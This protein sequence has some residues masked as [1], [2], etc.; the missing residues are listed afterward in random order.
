MDLLWN[1]KTRLI[2]LILIS[3]LTNVIPTTTFAQLETRSPYHEG[4]DMQL[5]TGTQNATLPSGLCDNNGSLYT[6]NPM[7]AI[8]QNLPTITC[9]D[10]STIGP[11]NGT[12]VTHCSPTP[13]CPHGQSPMPDRTCLPPCGGSGN[14]TCMWK[15]TDGNYTQSNAAEQFMYKTKNYTDYT[16]N[17]G[18]PGQTICDQQGLECYAFGLAAGSAHSGTPCPTLYNN[19]TKQQQFCSGYKDGSTN[20]AK[21][22]SKGGIICDNENNTGCHRDITNATIGGYPCVHG[23]PYIPDR[24]GNCPPPTYMRSPASH[25]NVSCGQILC[26]DLGWNRGQDSGFQHCPTAVDALPVSVDNITIVNRGQVYAYCNGFSDGEQALAN[27][28]NIRSHVSTS[29]VLP[30]NATGF[31]DTIKIMPNGSAAEIGHS[32]IINQTHTSPRLN[33]A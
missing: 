28:P 16:F 14:M 3:F 4:P 9:W 20:P 10:G 11:V 26:Y 29:M 8:A 31:S 1:M 2:F 13:I 12:Y 6:C 32:H 18:Y 15:S 33:M 21:Y 5:L 30:H 23:P 25:S 7:P 19:Q 17:P 22:D 27:H 24:N